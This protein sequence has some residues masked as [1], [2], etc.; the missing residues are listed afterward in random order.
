[1]HRSAARRFTALSHAGLMARSPFKERAVVSDRQ[2]SPADASAA[3]GRDWQVAARRS[4]RRART[5]PSEAN[6]TLRQR[7]GPIE[8][9]QVWMQLGPSMQRRSAS[10]TMPGLQTGCAGPVSDGRSAPQNQASSAPTWSPSSR[11][12][13]EQRAIPR[14][15]TLPNA[16]AP[17]GT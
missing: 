15:I 1:M 3:A 13:S 7:P 6:E 8:G 11:T 5:V 4:G 14:R 10:V 17:T 12:S 16:P 2:M 9:A